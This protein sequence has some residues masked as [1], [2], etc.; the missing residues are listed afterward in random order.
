MSSAW[1]QGSGAPV[2]RVINADRESSSVAVL[3]NETP[4]PGVLQFREAS[5]GLPLKPG[6]YVLNV[7]DPASSLPL[8]APVEVNA[9]QGEVITVVA[10]P[11]TTDPLHKLSPVVIESKPEAAKS[12]KAL[13]TFAL[14]SKAVNE[15]DVHAGWFRIISDLKAGSFEGPTEVSPG[16]YKVT[17]KA[18]NETVLGPIELKPEAGK[19]YLIVAFDPATSDGAAKLAHQV[20]NTSSESTA[21]ASIIQPR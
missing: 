17:A 21:S 10:A 6:K 11:S 12:D 3:V 9:N 5:S 20:Y 13:A 18:G 4:L 1:A 16:T 2:L 8:A 15:L 14:A 19:S 7:V